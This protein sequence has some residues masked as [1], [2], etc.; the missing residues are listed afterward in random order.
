MAD[1]N[2]TILEQLR[3]FG[4]VMCDSLDT[5]LGKELGPFAGVTSNQFIALFELTKDPE[6]C[7]A[8]LQEACKHAVAFEA[9]PEQRV[10]AGVKL[11]MILLARRMLPYLEPNSRIFI[12]CSMRSALSCDATV[13]DVRMLVDLARRLPDGGEELASRLCIKIPST[14]EAL[15]AAKI[16]KKEHGI[17]TLGTAMF[18]LQQGVLASECG[19][20]HI[21]PY[22]NELKMHFAKNGEVDQN[23]LFGVVRDIWT[24]YRAPD[25]QS[26][27]VLMPAS[28]IITDDVLAFSGVD[29]LT[30]P[31][32]HLRT[33]AEKPSSV[34][35]SD[36]KP[37]QRKYIP[38]D[39]FPTAASNA[40]FAALTG[41]ADDEARYRKH[42]GE[43][44]E[45]TRKLKEALD[46][47]LI[48]EEKLEALVAAELAKMA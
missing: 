4:V 21:S 46:T 18:S 23:K 30:I 43:D 10:G 47:F 34:T 39:P 45:A 9:D 1:S 28:F 13:A 36:I 33:F 7:A 2:P 3:S 8:I 26:S 17:A 44:V 41:V 6:I 14:W 5:D 20:T 16:L 37:L 11:V 38:I 48:Y 42:F 31:A 27:T 29:A 25:V 35:P 32:H 22:V 40:R 12:Q 15:S 24:Y 19:C